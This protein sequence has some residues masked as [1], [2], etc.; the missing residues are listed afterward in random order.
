[1]TLDTWRLFYPEERIFVGFLE[2]IHFFPEDFYRPSSVF[3]VDLLS[4]PPSWRGRHARSENSM[5]GGV[6]I[7]LAQNYRRQME[8]F[9]EHFGAMPRSGASARSGWSRTL[10][11]SGASPTPVELL[12]LE[13]WTGSPEA[14]VREGPD[15]RVAPC[16]PRS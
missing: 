7:Q 4:G 1:M 2:D 3:H 16:P 15:S 14:D 10:R 6:A 11:P 5:P 8:R 13:E 12:P 9:E